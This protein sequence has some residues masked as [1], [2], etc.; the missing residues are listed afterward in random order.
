MPFLYYLCVLPLSI[1]FRRVLFRKEE[2]DG[3]VSDVSRQNYHDAIVI[4]ATRRVTA[5]SKISRYGL[6]WIA[7]GCTAFTSRLSPTVERFVQQRWSNDCSLVRS[8]MSLDSRVFSCKCWF[9]NVINLKW[10]FKLRDWRFVDKFRLPELIGSS[11]KPNE[12][13]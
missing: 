2:R 11:N 3:I 9:A 1:S 7:A 6:A 5:A 10:D 12:P 13:H 4:I 8:I